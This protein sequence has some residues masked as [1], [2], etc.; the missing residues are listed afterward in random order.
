M[1]GLPDAQEPRALSPMGWLNIY[2]RKRWRGRFRLYAEDLL[3]HE[4][5]GAD[6]DGG[7]GADDPGSV[8]VGAVVSPDA[9]QEVLDFERPQPDVS[10]TE[11]R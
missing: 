8:V 11:P 2:V 5:E 6:E 9:Q 4:Q 7:E 10:G 3:P 1:S